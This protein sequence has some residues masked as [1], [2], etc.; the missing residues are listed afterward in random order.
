MKRPFCSA[1]AGIMA[2]TFLAVTSSMVRGQK[3]APKPAPTFD[4]DVAPILF[5]HCA[6]CHCP[7]QV[8]PFPLLTYQEAAK[9]ASLIAT[10]TASHYMPPWKPV[11]GYGEFKG[12]NYLTSA[13]IATLR[14]WADAEAPEGNSTDLPATPHFSSG[15]SFGQ[16]DLVLKMPKP[17][18]IPA[19]GEDIYRC[20]AFPLNLPAGSSIA[21]FDVHPGNRKVLHHSILYLNPDGTAVKLGTKSTAPGYPCFGGPGVRTA[22][23]L[24]GWAPG[25]APHLL[26]LGVGTKVPRGS[27]LVM[28]IHYHPSGKPETDQSEVGLYFAKGRVSKTVFW[29]PLSHRDL[30][31]PAGN[32]R[33]QVTTTFVTPVSL[34][35]IAIF[36]HMHLLGREMKVTATLPDGEVRPMIWIKDWDFNWQG[37]YVYK[38]PLVLPKGTTIKLQATYD[39]SSNNPRNPYSPPR[40][41]RWGEN[42]TDEM[43][44]AF[45]ECETSHPA[46]RRQV[47]LSLARQL[48]L[49]RYRRRRFFETNEK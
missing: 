13:E 31:I 5:K 3:P 19:D 18:H 38:T 24:G 43:C 34:E 37:Q 47:L 25:A 16:P 41:V 20:F 35:V 39:N 28:Q 29:I 45:I 14:A 32:P 49:W 17:F 27:D 30:K 2:F 33:Y 48:G 23:S 26:P 7:G 4:K 6:T 1:T 22:G 46:D 15:W 44:F 8:A 10:V 9:R 12:A 40:V 42:T 36:P 21:G 11:S